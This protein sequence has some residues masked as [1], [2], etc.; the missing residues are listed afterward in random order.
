MSVKKGDPEW[1]LLKPARCQGSAGGSLEARKPGEAQRRKARGAFEGPQ[2]SVEHLGNIESEVVPRVCNVA[3]AVAAGTTDADDHVD[4]AVAAA[5]GAVVVVAV[6][7][8]AVMVGTMVAMGTFVRTSAHS[9]VPCGWLGEN[10]DPAL[11]A[12]EQVVAQFVQA[13]VAH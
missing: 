3:P 5:G 13:R 4:D 2:Q 12:G 7:V 10:A 6:V 1:Q 11:S 8:V 9:L